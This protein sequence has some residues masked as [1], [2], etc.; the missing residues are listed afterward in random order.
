MTVAEGRFQL[1][2]HITPPLTAGLYRFHTTQDLDATNDKGALGPDVLEVDPLDLHVEVT[3]PRYQLPPDQVLSTFPPAGTE[4]AYG[5]RL[6]Q[7]VIKRRTLPWERSVTSSAETPWMALVLV[8]EGEAEVV[9]NVKVAQC[10]SP[11]VTLTGPVDVETGNHLAIR[12]S[13]VERIMPTRLDVPLLAHAREV[14]LHDTELMMG[15]DD[16]FLA[17]VISNRLPVGGRGPDGREVPV[18][19]TA[20]LVNLEGQFDRLLEHSPPH[21]FVSDFAQ[22]A[23]D[24]VVVTAA[25]HDQTVMG[26]AS[27]IS[28]AKVTNTI[29][30]VRGL[31]TAE[32]TATRVVV[33]DQVPAAYAGTLAWQEKAHPSAETTFAAMDRASVHPRLGDLVD[34][35]LRF[36]VLLHW[37]FV[38]T[39]TTTF[40]K[41][42]TELDSGLLG[43]V[44]EHPVES[45]GRVPLEV[46]ETGHV[47]LVQRTRRGDEVRAWYRGPLLPHP[48]DLVADRLPLAHVA[49]QLRTVIP[50]GREDLSLAAAFEIG[51][52]LAL[53]SPAMVAALLRWRQTDY[54]AARQKTLWDSVLPGLASAPGFT[55]QY[56]A[57]LSRALGLGIAHTLATSPEATVGDPRPLFPLATPLPMDG[58]DLAAVTR[59]LG[60]DLGVDDVGVML[61]KARAL[62]VPE[63]RLSDLPAREQGALTRLTLQT[64]LGLAVTAF[65]SD[66]LA[67]RL[68]PQP[69][70]GP[71]LPRTVP[72]ARP[73]RDVLDDALGL[74]DPVR[75]PGTTPDQREGG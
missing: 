9:R 63:L 17:V 6:P 29:G 39:G 60:M 66:A 7:V 18:T 1:Y 62:D 4:G 37:T 28:A 15:D 12:R 56:G 44:G 11:G 61:E 40:E 13:M 8:A 45:S 49:D 20:A 65:A 68:E 69:F 51:R 53:N 41:L 57:G 23:V 74:T 2:T 3:S 72:A 16:G 19:Y 55:A 27:G 59:G 34:P 54:Q 22:L 5:S 73:T 26:M 32:A 48:A 30:G 71:T 75:P 38:S 52:L 24:R 46:V 31:G 70:L 50:D 25:A 47:G 33:G 42:M 64:H 67:N 14:D 21:V 36:P 35:V 58:V 43:T 10:V